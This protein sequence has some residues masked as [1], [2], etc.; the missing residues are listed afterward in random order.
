MAPPSTATPPRDRQRWLDAVVGLRTLRYAAAI[1]LVVLAF[2]FL[3]PGSGLGVAWLTGVVVALF[4]AW[5]AAATWLGR[6]AR[7]ATQAAQAGDLRAAAETWGRCAR[8]SVGRRRAYA[9]LSVGML[10]FRLGELAPAGAALAA[11]ERS[12]GVVP[13][14]YGQGV[15]SFLSLVLA[16]QGELEPAAGWAAQ[17]RKRRVPAGLGTA[18]LHLAAEAVVASRAGDATDAATRIEQAWPELA[19][20]YQAADLRP[21]R[22]VRAFLLGA[23]GRPGEE[24][25]VAALAREHRW[26]GAEWPE[27]AAFLGQPPAEDG[28]AQA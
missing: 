2:V 19:R 6:L 27:L 11:V 21:L 14:R 8:W 5:L 7:R 12:H 23:A 18:R 9:Q 15:A 3:L 13:S 4:L 28:A 10:R 1:W 24:E 16:L 17:A 26:M 20:S 22:L 25:E